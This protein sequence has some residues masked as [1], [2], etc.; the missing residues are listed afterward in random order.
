LVEGAGD[1]AVNGVYVR[2]EED[3]GLENNVDVMFVKEAREGEC[4]SD[5]G[6]YRRHSTWAITSCVDHS[7]I[8]YSCEVPEGDPSALYRA[9]Y[10]GWMAVGSSYPAPTCTWNPGKHNSKTAAEGFVAPNLVEAKKKSIED[11]N[12]GDHDDGCR[13]YSLE[14]MLMLPSDEGHENNDYHSDFDDSC[15]SFN[16]SASSKRLMAKKS[17]GTRR[18]RVDDDIN[19]GSCRSL[20]LDESWRS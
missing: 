5:Y 16:L 11:I 20:I 9:P 7:N 12:Q 14:T 6:M 17:K 4:I 8:L 19:D 3:I 13:R 15:M 2:M 18:L 1:D 10:L